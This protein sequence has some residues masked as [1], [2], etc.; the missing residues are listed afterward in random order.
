MQEVGDEVF[1]CIDEANAI[2]NDVKAHVA[3][4]V[5]SS[6]LV[7]SATK[8]YLNIRTIESA[9]CCVQVTGRGFKIVSSQY[10]TIDEEPALGPDGEPEEEEIFE[11]PYALLDKIS[12]RYV[13]SFGNKLCQQLR[14]L[15]Q[16]R[17]EFHEEDE[18]E[19]E[20]E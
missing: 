20:D 7:S 11:T 16:M 4:I 2:I 13:E 8:I 9:T 1:N 3:E 10:D 5:I 18:E 14:Q 12:P 15:Q 6:K 17:T 19:D